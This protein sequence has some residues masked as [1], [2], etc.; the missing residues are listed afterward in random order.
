MIDPQI[1]PAL[2][3]A[4]DQVIDPE[5]R[6][7]ITELNM[8]ARAQV[9][10]GKAQA[11]IKLTIVGCPAANHITEDVTNALESVVGAGN[12]TVNVSV[13]TPTERK[14]LLEKLGR[15]TKTNQ[16]GPGTLTRIIQVSSG[17]GGVG[18]STIATNLAVAM[19]RRGLSVGIL[20]ADVYG[21]SIPG[22]LGITTGPT[23][24]D[25][26]MLPPRGFDV[27]AISIGMFVGDAPAVS[28]RGP[29]LHRTLKQ[30]VTDVYFG[31]LDVLVVDLPPGT[32]DVAISAGQLM[33]DAEVVVV[34]TPQSSASDVAFRSG[35]VAAQTGQR[36]IG[37]IENMSYLPLPDGSQ[38]DIFGSGGGARA[39]AELTSHLGYNVPVLG[40]IPI[41]QTLREDADA[42]TPA[43]VTHPADEA[44]AT[45]TDIA[46]QLSIRSTPRGHRGLP[47]SPK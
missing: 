45:L 8:V 3:A 42:G 25:D 30:F 43:V 16:F 26:M 31:D 22:Q 41:S 40:Q 37:V 9:V 28:W 11:D 20:D 19:A 17:K 35:V 38:Q 4:L 29:M 10:D 39:A 2:V 47:I 46:A 34:T 12:A 5:I 36:V 14:A 27:Q 23:Q 44:A 21:F 13:M 1:D 32:G 6:K 24:V 7:P 15:G 33:P 18:K